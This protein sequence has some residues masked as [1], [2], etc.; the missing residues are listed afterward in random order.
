MKQNSDADLEGFTNELVVHLFDNSDLKARRLEAETVQANLEGGSSAE[1]LA[2]TAV[3]LNS[4]G[5]AK[6]LCIW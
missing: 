5:S 1:V 4:K 6:T 2:K 3:D